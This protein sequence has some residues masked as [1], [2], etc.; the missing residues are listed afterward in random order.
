MPVTN[1]VL[2]EFRDRPAPVPRNTFYGL[3]NRDFEKLNSDLVT[4]KF[5]H[6]FNDGLITAKPTSFQQ[7][8][9]RL[10]GDAAAFCKQQFNRH[11]S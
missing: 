2:V 7:L 11:Q 1:N 8:V 5:E 6:D 9:T 3:R 4:L 10:D